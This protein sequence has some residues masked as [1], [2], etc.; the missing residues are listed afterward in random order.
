MTPTLEAIVPYRQALVVYAYEVERVVT[1]EYPHARLLVAH[2]GLVAGK[3][4]SIPKTRGMSYLLTVEEMN[5]RPELEGERVI[6][7]MRGDNLPIYYE[8]S[9]P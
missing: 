8:I 6:M 4:R 1:G 3:V 7:D 9:R 2:W 5:D